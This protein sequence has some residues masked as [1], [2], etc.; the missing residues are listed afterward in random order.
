M[1]CLPLLGIIYGF[2]SD[3][4]DQHL[5]SIVSRNCQAVNSQGVASEIRHLLEQPAY[6]LDGYTHSLQDFIRRKLV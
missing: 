4:V 5:N 3:F 6:Q 1:Y 2:L